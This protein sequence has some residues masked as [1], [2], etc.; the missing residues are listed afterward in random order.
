MGGACRGIMLSLRALKLL[1]VWVAPDHLVSSA[2]ILLE[3]HGLRAIAVLDAGEIVGVVTPDSLIGHADFT[4]VGATMSPPSLILDGDLTVREA[5]DQFV[6]TNADF[7]PVVA[8]TAYLGMV[9]ANMLLQEL[10]RSWDPLTGLSWSDQLREWGIDNL[11]RGNEITILFIDLDDFGQYNKRFGHIVGDHVLQRVAA[12]LADSIDPETDIL[13][14]YGG[15]E[16][17][18]GT[19]KD[20]ADADEMASMLK[21]KGGEVFIGEAEDTVE[22]TIGIQGGKRGKERESI[23]YAA[24]LDNL[25]NLASKDCIAQKNAR[26][27]LADRDLPSLAAVELPVPPSPQESI[28]VVSVFADDH[29]SNS[30]TQ[31]IISVGEAVVSGVSARMGKSVIES[32]AQATAKALERKF[33]DRP[34]TINDIHLTQS[35]EGQRLVTV[36]AQVLHEDQSLVVGGVKAVEQDLYS[37]VALATIQAFQQVP[38]ANS[39]P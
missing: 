11:R 5:S 27:A 14:R 30:L 13:V 36:S 17:A 37:D 22:F 38:V 24:T 20:R 10:G 4:P 39:H 32:I 2:R 7:A 1:P 35:A 12:M 28:R 18:I 16:F 19:L 23:H 9:T 26:Q 8:D 34:M 31:V 33:P 25:I 29:T 15:D 21:R 3:G 6:K